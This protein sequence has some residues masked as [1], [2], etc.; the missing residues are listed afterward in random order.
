MNKQSLTIIY[1]FCLFL[2]FLPINSFTQN[3]KPSNT[4]NRKAVVAGQFYAGTKENLTKDLQTLFASA[5]KRQQDA[6]ANIAT[7]RLCF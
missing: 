6:R 7:C 4:M 1:F 2:F 3:K 5:K